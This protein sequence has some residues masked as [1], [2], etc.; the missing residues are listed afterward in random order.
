MDKN[1]KI[2]LI[3]CIIIVIGLAVF[4]YQ[5]FFSV[6]GFENKTLVKGLQISLPINSNFVD[7]GENTFHD[8]KTNLNIKI[9]KSENDII[10]ANISNP[11]NTI[12]SGS[13]SIKIFKDYE[14][15]SNGDIG[16]KISDIEDGN[17]NIAMKIAENIVLA[18]SIKL[19]KISEEKAKEFAKKYMDYLIENNPGDNS[20]VFN[21]IILTE[22]NGK[23]AYKVTFTSNVNAYGSSFSGKDIVYVDAYNGKII[24]GG[25]S[26]EN[27]YKNH[28][29]T[30]LS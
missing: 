22:Y 24:S 29:G 15:V 2:L 28:G 13:N 12:D 8:D 20:Y 27:Y 11:E 10:D 21:D 1:K 17:K 25:L 4:S 30:F 19:E 5:S 9:L 23:K 3:V 6:P 16:I 7:V 26:V 14:I 18:P